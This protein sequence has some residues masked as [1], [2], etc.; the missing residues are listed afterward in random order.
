MKVVITPLPVDIDAE[1]EDQKFIEKLKTAFPTVTFRFATTVDEQVREIKD[2]DVYCGPASRKVFLA[3]ER[4]RW[5][6]H[7]GM[8]I[9]GIGDIPELIESDVVLTN[10]PGPHAA[11]MADHAFGMVL[12]LAHLLHKL[13]DDQRAHRWDRM[14]YSRRQVEVTGRAMGILALGE[15]GLA[16][17]RRAQGFG[18]KVYAV[19]RHPDSVRQRSDGG[20]PTENGDVWGTE[21]LDDMLRIV[22]WFVVTAP[23]TAETRSLIDRRKFGLMKPSSYVI[24]ISRGGI[25][26][27]A[28]LIDALRSGQIAGAG[29]D[30]LEVEPLPDDS[31]LWDMDNVLI[32]SHASALTPELFDGRREIFKE[33]LRRFLANEPFLYVCNKRAGF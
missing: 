3:A 10:C 2:A 24:A 26:D 17:A 30:A 27:E 22:D 11:P 6:H 32:S 1:K 8:G 23:L 20:L 21:R 15:V 16:V 4:L 33:N 18:M 13:W 19:D 5:L 9:D 14:Q 28:A 25:I 31:P 12:T 7:P 29:L